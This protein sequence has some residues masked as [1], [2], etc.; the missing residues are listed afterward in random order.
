MTLTEF[1][2]LPPEQQIDVLRR[3]SVYLCNRKTDN[4]THFLYQADAFYVEVTYDHATN[5]II[6]LLGFQSTL[7]LEPYLNKI[8]LKHIS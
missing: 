4:Y 3:N 8:K 1:T 5:K 2:N 7:L 6:N